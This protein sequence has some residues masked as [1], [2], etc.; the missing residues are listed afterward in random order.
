MAR[1][2]GIPK[3]LRDLGNYSFSKRDGYF[4]IMEKAGV[5]AKRIAEDPVFSSFRGNSIEFRQAT[6]ISKLI[7]MP[8]KRF[9]KTASD[10]YMVARLNGRIIKVQQSDT[11]NPPGLRNIIDGDIKLLTGFNFNKNAG[12]EDIFPIPF[13]TT[14]NRQTGDHRITIP[15]FIPATFISAPQVATH[16][17]INSTAAEIR[18][19]KNTFNVQVCGTGVCPLDDTATGSF[20]LQ[21]ALPPKSIHPLLLFLGIEF[22]QLANEKMKPLPKKENAFAIVAVCP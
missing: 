4:K 13:T 15:E 8:V 5:D 19:A 3:A 17:R 2:K 11:K 16:F 7:R 9:T 1:A 6:E 22:L 20:A 14:F 12:L 10:T 21:H 18:F